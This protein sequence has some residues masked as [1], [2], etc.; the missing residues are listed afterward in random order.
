MLPSSRMMMMQRDNPRLLTGLE[1]LRLQG[2]GVDILLAGAE[3]GFNDRFYMNLAGNAFNG[4]AF[5]ASFLA[6]LIA[7]HA[8]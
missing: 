1:A 2:F 8:S 5:A 6:A 4:G 3:A 7:T